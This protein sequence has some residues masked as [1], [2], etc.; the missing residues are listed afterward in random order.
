MT[1][2]NDASIDEGNKLR[3]VM[4]FALRYEQDTGARELIAKLYDPYAL[5]MNPALVLDHP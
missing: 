1:L 3:L 2:L 4:L 5:P